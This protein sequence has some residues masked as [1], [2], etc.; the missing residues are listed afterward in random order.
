[1]I[2]GPDLPAWC[3]TQDLEVKTTWLPCL[4]LLFQVFSLIKKKNKNFNICLDG[5]TLNICLDGHQGKYFKK[6]Q[7]VLYEKRK[8]LIF[9]SFSFYI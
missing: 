6:S 4:H 3:S 8:G 2:A 7:L 1:M 5:K 9:L